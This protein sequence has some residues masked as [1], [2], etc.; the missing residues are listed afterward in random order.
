MAKP[1]YGHW[2]VGTRDDPSWQQQK[3]RIREVDVEMGNCGRD[4]NGRNLGIYFVPAR[5]FPTRPAVGF[6]SRRLPPRRKVSRSRPDCSQPSHYCLPT[7]CFDPIPTF[8]HSLSHPAS[9]YWG[10]YFQLVR[11]RFSGVLMIDTWYITIDATVLCN[12]TLDATT[13]E[14]TGDYRST[15][16]CCFF[17]G[18][19]L[20]FA[21]IDEC[22]LL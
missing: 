2:A 21:E 19:P 15:R 12:C 22:I 10:R 17:L 8:A 6:C 7:D 18:V 20:D 5:D 4:G 13:V 1:K 9:H 3:T 14:E 11:H 16:T